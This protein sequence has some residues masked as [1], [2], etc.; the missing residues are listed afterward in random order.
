MQ[1]FTGLKVSAS[2]RARHQACE[3]HLAAVISFKFVP[4]NCSVPETP[5]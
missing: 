4:A 5:E 2:S 3:M 1:V